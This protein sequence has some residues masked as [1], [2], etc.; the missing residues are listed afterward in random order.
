M[1]T[2][3]P[4]PAEPA[5]RTPSEAQRAALEARAA[6]LRAEVERL[7]ARAA[8][9]R[10][11]RPRFLLWT[12][13]AIVLCAAWRPGRVDARGPRAELLGGRATVGG[14]RLEEV[15]AWAR[16]SPGDLL[17]AGP[18][19]RLALEVGEG[20]IVLDAGAELLVERLGPPSLRLRRGSAEVLGPIA[21][22]TNAGVLNVAAGAVVAAPAFRELVP[23]KGG[24]ASTLTDA[25]GVA[26]VTRGGL[27]RP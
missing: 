11:G 19:A 5:P 4:N 21:L 25:G 23:G 8:P 2:P 15:G 6:H 7:R 13:V 24:A 17:V 26:Q 27:A 3:G 20:R 12:C 18:D 10:R 22:V 1:V 16:V 14:H 9:E